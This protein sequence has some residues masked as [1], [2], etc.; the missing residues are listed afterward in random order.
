LI[1][2]GQKREEAFWACASGLLAASV[3]ATLVSEPITALDFYQVTP[4]SIVANLLV[5][6]LAGLITVVGTIS[7]AASLLSFSL[8]GL[9]NNANWA[10]AKLMIAIVSFFAHEPGAAIN[11]PDLR[12]VSQPSPFFVAAPLQDSACLLV[13]NRGHS[14]LIDTGREVPP[15]SV[16]AK[17]LQFYG[18]NRL[19][20]LILAQ[21][22]TP[23]NGGAALI[24]RQ[25]HP[26][27]ILLPVLASR[28][29]LHLTLRD[30]AAVAGASIEPRQ[31]G[32]VLDLG[33]GLRAE[34]LGPA[35]A[36]AATHEDD[37]SLVLLF[38]AS[39]GTLLWAG[40][41]GAAGQRELMG[42]F[43]GL[44]ADVLV[45]GGDT[46]PDSAWLR[47]LGNPFWLRLPPRQR[48][49]NAPSAMESESA[50]TA[51][52]PLEQTGAVTVHFTGGPSPGVE[53]TPWVA[54]P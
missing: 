25:F 33:P 29:P 37:R 7:V 47:A 8:A 24:A 15:P 46:A 49:L 2:A 45:W 39:G 10:L 23:D 54:L 13:K 44:H 53:L 16:P 42:A 20:A 36:S 50:P 12:A 38:H 5:V 48:Y 11:V 4:I 28:S 19:D 51:P 34:V 6:P 43:P 31:R 9:F 22:S 1:T 21:P 27:Q 14:W 32:Q 17:L 40:R 41:L 35:P 30:T 3:A 26:R 18:I 52:W